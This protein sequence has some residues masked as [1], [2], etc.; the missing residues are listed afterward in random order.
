MP[1]AIESVRKLN[2]KITITCIVGFVLSYYAFRVEVAKENDDSYEAMC[3]ISEHVSC[4]KAFSSEYGKGFG[5]IPETSPLN[6]PNPVYGLLFYALVALMSTSNRYILSIQ[7]VILAV[8]ANILTIYLA[9]IL[10]IQ[11]NICIVCV[12][13]YIT[14]AVLLTLVVKKHRRLFKNGTNKKKSR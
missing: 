6:M 3:D 5:I 4:T 11:K 9:S 10:Y 12:S 8:C 1:A 7:V 14:N 13:T 2:F